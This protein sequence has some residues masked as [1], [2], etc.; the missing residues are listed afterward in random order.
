MGSFRR[1]ISQSSYGEIDG[2]GLVKF[3]DGDW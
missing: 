2:Y 1:S 3:P